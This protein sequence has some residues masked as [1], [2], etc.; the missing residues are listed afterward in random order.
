MV[1]CQPLD[2][3]LNFDCCFADGCVEGNSGIFIDLFFDVI[4]DLATPL[5]GMLSG[6]DNVKVRVPSCP[7]F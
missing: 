6:W 2:L 5:L 1:L 4:D 7:S 3:L